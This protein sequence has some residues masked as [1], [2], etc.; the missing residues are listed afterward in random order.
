MNVGDLVY[1]NGSNREVSGVIL[2]I[3]E[4]GAYVLLNNNKE[5]WYGYG[6]LEVFYESR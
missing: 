6:W 2:R 4:N 5:G 3:Y 1:I